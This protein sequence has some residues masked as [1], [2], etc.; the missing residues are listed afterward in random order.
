MEPNTAFDKHESVSF[1][2]H[3]HSRLR[4]WI[5]LYL[6]PL[7]LLFSI[8]VVAFIWGHLVL[9][10]MYDSSFAK[11]QLDDSAER[12]VALMGVPHRVHRDMPK[13]AEQRDV[14]FYIYN[15]YPFP[16]GENLLVRH[17]W[18]VRIDHRNRVVGK[19]Y[20]DDGC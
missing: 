10:R 2:N 5:C 16:V 19:N 18:C 6:L 20:S 17:Q 9:V 3:S 11:L 8:S 13:W 15:V 1:H 4:R 12:A 14:T 7:L